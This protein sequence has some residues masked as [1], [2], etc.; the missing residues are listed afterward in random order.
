MWFFKIVLSLPLCLGPSKLKG[1]ANV[2]LVGSGDPRHIFK[3]IAGLQ[4]TDGLHVSLSFLLVVICVTLCMSYKC[5]SS[6]VLQV[7]VVENSMEVVA[8]QLLLLYLALIPPESMGNNGD[9]DIVIDSLLVH[10]RKVAVWFTFIS[11]AVFNA[12]RED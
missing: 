5:F 10:I 11:F 8:R 6:S 9:L 12:F 1:E 2:L 7:W 4:N 3:T